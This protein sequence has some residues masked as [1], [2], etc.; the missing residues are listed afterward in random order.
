MDIILQNR[1]VKFELRVSPRARGVYLKISPAEGL[2]VV[3]PRFYNMRNVPDILHKKERWILRNL[4][5]ISRQRQHRQLFGDGIKIFVAGRMKIFHLL[6]LEQ[7]YRAVEETND[8]ITIG[9]PRGK[10]VTHRHAIVRERLERYLR[11]KGRR[12][13]S[14]RVHHI[15]A[16]MEAR[17]GTITIRSQK[18]RWGSCT[19]HNN[20]NFNWRLLLMP[21]EVIDY[22]IMHELAHTFH[23]NHSKKFYA[24]LEKFCPDYK[25]RRKILREMQERLPL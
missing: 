14:E 7:G 3:V 6:P 21:S 12:F 9:E 1:E 23:H 5:K 16:T 4:E 13:F 19:R 8:T 17:F 20:L 2:E 15:G 24:V 11:L 25:K 18:S 10:T 22:V